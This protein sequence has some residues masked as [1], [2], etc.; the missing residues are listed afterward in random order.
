MPKALAPIPAR[1]EVRASRHLS[2]K[3]SLE[4]VRK[5]FAKIPEHRT[6]RIEFSLVDTL[7]SAAAVFG[8]K[9]PSLLKFDENR[10]E[11]HIRHNLCT[12]YGVAGQAPCDT[13]MR[14][15]LD[16]VEPAEIGKGFDRLHRILERQGVLKEFN[17][18]GALVILLDAT[19]EYSS[20]CVCCP[21]CCTRT[22]SDG[23][24]E[25][26]HQMLAAVIAHP[27][28]KT[29]LALAPEPIVKQENA[30]KND[31]E[32]NAAKRMLPKIRALYPKRRI[33]ITADGLYSKGPF[34]KLLKELKFDYILVAKEGDHVS[35]VNEYSKRRATEAQEYEETPE[36]VTQGFGWVNGLP[37]NA[38]HADIKVNLLNFWE[39]KK[40]EEKPNTWIWITNIQLM[41]HNVRRIM[42]AGRC[43]WKVEN[44]TFNTL[45][46]QGYHLEHNYGHGKRHLATVLGLLMML[47]FLIDQIQ[48]TG[49]RLF[50]AARNRLY[51]RTSVW[52]KLR[53]FFANY[54]I[55][56]WEDIWLSMIYGNQRGPLIP[57][58]S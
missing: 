44:E 42:R 28:K 13:Q 26:D 35:L 6:G 14:A 45:K 43:R 5:T 7:M 34:I 36:G 57:N 20:S 29:V 30:S 25:Y 58:T 10:Q 37:L 52:E 8:L 56:S 17:S 39:I 54:F 15:I 46:N 2:I 49:C 22:R 12:L 40:D 23:T 33:I 4:V 31:C 55:A 24:V 11:A 38:A 51:S 16:P 53:G 47:M 41:R 50:Q 18:M 32:I 1:K 19:G 48:E 21:D 3:P 27:D 9:F